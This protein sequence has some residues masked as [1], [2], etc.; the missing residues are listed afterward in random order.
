MNENRQLAQ[1][2]RNIAAVYEIMGKSFFEIAAYKRAADSV[3]QS[4]TDLRQLWKNGSLD[5]V[6]GLGKALLGYMTEYF[7]TGKIKH[8]ETVYKKAPEGFFELLTV[9]SIGPKKAYELSTK[10]NIH[11]IDD[12]EKAI[13]SNLVATLPRFGQKSQDQ[14]ANNLHRVVAKSHRTPIWAV[15]PVVKDITA[16]M[17]KDPKVQDFDALGSFRRR[18]NSVGDLDFAATSKDTESAVDR[19]ISYPERNAVVEKGPSSA[20]ITLKGSGLQVDLLVSNPDS[21]GSLL[22]HFTG[23]REHNIALRTLAVKKGLSLSEKGIKL[24]NGK[25]KKF[26]SESDFYKFLGLSFI[27]PELREDTGEIELAK[28]SLIPKLVEAKDIKGD[29]HIHSNFFTTSMHDFGSSSIEEL[30]QAAKQKKYA[31]LG[32][33]DHPPSEKS[34]LDKNTIKQIKSHQTTINKLNEHKNY[35]RVLNLLEVD[36][37]PDGEIKFPK[38]FYKYYEAFIAGVHS[39][40]SQ[41]KDQMTS[42][43]IKGLSNPK[44]FGLSHPT[45]RLIDKREGYEADWE[46]IFEFCAANQKVLEINASVDRLDLTEALVRL[47]KG[48]GCIFMINTDTHEI[49]SLELLH[50]GL[51]VARRGGL[52]AEDILN[53]WSLPKLLKFFER[54]A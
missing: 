13:K 40:F 1:T 44:V 48:K 39:S 52:E 2:L 4:A 33:S 45:G 41:T 50:Y 3:E 36:I 14:I 19:F 38:E 16:W 15:D 29:F 25:I 32:I 35:P 11:S 27:P 17:L 26:S 12:L 6:P 22:Q 34:W 5:T 53:T 23:S 20:T 28:K 30:T 42:R 10:L 43:I 8:F 54:F 37:S 9:P 47:A 31:Y 51:D 7:E 49:S 21:Y 46:K 18:L 24:K